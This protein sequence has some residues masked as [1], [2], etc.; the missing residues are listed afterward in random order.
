MAKKEVVEAQEASSGFNVVSFL[1]GTRE[2]LQKVVWPDRQQLV[3]ESAGVLL[4]VILSAS[5]IYLVDN[6]FR[7]ASGQVFG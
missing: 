2:E 4:M 3:S 6:F 5:I 1:Q 7:W